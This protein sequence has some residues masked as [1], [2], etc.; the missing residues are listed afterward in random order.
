MQDRCL[1]AH[2]S[3][4]KEEG[5]RVTHGWGTPE[6]GRV[7]GFGEKDTKKNMKKKQEDGRHGDGEAATLLKS[8]GWLP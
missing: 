6:L 8:S 4:R 7:R 2:R 1:T 3:M 5:G